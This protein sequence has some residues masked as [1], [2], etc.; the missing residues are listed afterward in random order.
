[1]GNENLPQKQ[2]SKQN[3]DASTLLLNVLRFKGKGFKP[4]LF[5]G[6]IQHL[7]CAECE[8]V[9]FDPV[10]IECGQHSENLDD[11]KIHNLYCN[12]CLEN[13]IQKYKGC[14]PISRRKKLIIRKTEQ[15]IISKKK[16]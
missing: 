11:E 15:C 2:N 12:D 13:V 14:C 4:T 16:E 5:D 10:S 8:S 1:M 3:H 7:N 9:C 6:N